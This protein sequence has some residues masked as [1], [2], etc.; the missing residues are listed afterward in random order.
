ML[1]KLIAP[2]LAATLVLA[3]CESSTAPAATTSEDDFA[4]VMFGEAGTS[5]EN[6]MGPQAGDRPFDGRSAFPPL[7]DSLRL[8]QAQRD[9][10]TALRTRFRTANQSTLDSMKAIFEA[11]KTARQGGA[12]REE[13]RA[14]L[15]TGRP[16]AEALRPKV[17]I[18]H[19]AIRA[20][21]TDA[22]RAWLE[23]NRPRRFPMPMG[24]RP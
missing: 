10:I 3:A 15:V 17:I 21:L 5:L 2:A 20:V 12:T 8:T 14:I 9:S 18:L 13:V 22:Q 19:L 24:P 11:A 6:T 4:L 1:R 16:L 23:A 7:P